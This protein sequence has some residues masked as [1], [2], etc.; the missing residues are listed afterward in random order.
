MT[1]VLSIGTIK[2]FKPL[3]IE[4]VNVFKNNGVSEL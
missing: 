4:D 2:N 3:K 1:P